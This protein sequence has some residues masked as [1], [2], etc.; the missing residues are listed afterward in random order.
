MAEME[1]EVEI[2]YLRL[3]LICGLSLI[4][5]LKN[6]LERKMEE[7][8]VKEIVREQMEKIYTLMFLLVQYL[9]TQ[10]IVNFYV[11]YQNL[12]KL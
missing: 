6:I 4:L 3:I 11:S 8:V 7:M 2:L 1:E 9:K 10:V 12:T 5:S